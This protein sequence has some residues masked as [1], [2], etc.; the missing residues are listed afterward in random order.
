LAISGVVM[1]A[2]SGS[3]LRGDALAALTP[4]STRL[5]D[6]SDRMQAF[7]RI[8]QGGAA[9]LS[10]VTIKV[11]IVDEKSAAVVDRT[12]ALPATAFSAGRQADYSIRLPLS[13]LKAGQY[14]LSIEAAI[15]KRTVRRDV[16]F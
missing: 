11:R 15:G 14:W 1:T 2:S 5:F 13:T 10:P 6:S 4:T 12:D 7:L 9:A 8:Y 16:R 3:S